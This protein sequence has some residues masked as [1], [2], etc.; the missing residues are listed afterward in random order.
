MYQTNILLSLK[1]AS[2]KSVRLKN[3]STHAL[4]NMLGPFSIDIKTNE[5]IAIL[6]PS[7]AGKSTLL[8]IMSGLYGYFGDIEFLSK[9]LRQMSVQELSYKRAFLPQQ[10]ET[11]FNLRGELIIS[12]GRVSRK[13]DPELLQ[14]IRESARAARAEHLLERSYQTLSGGE[15]AR[16][17]LARIF[18]QLWDQ[19]NGI[20][21]IDEP[22]AALDPGLQIELLLAILKFCQERSLALVA[23]LHDIQQAIENFERLILI[24]DGKIMADL[25]SDPAPQRELE[26]LY[27]M[28]LERL[29]RPG[30][31]DLLIPSDLRCSYTN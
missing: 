25:P 19:H 31:K 4:A 13:H 30:R 28:N 9:P 18:A 22:L 2:L 21:L 11:A 8:Q 10:H 3:N 7:G 24:K 5:R 6:G 23:I 15:K 1:E 20:L 17:H 14:I 26:I 12:L 27:E 16:V 29:T